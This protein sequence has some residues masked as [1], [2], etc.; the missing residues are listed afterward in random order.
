MG[1]IFLVR[2]GQDED[3]ANGILNGRRNTPLTNLGRAQARNVADKLA[4]EGITLVISTPLLRGLETAIIIRRRLGIPAERHIVHSQLIERD[5][6]AMTGRPL[7]DI[8]IYGSN[9][10][11]TDHVLY[12]LKAKGSES[13]PRVLK[14]ARKVLDDIELHHRGENVLIVC[15]DDIGNMIRAAFHD[16]DWRSVLKFGRFENC[17]VYELP[18]PHLVSK[19]RIFTA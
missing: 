17:G 16:L 4:G 14:R 15:H 8:P 2:R 6:G 5:F 11:Y 1:K 13:F 19:V 12:F 18:D 7:L 3:N 10:L 9:L